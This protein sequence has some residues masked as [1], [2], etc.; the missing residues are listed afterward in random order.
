MRNLPL[1]LLVLPLASAQSTVPSY[2]RRASAT[3]QI[4]T[5]YGDFAVWID[6]TKWTQTDESATN[7]WGSIEFT[8]GPTLVQVWTEPKSRALTDPMIEEVL[9]QFRRMTNVAVVTLVSKQQRLVGGR[10]ILAVQFSITT[11]TPV[12]RDGRAYRDLRAYCYL[13]SGTSGSI[14]LIGSAPDT[15][16]NHEVGDIANFLN[17]VEIYDQELPSSD[18]TKNASSISSSAQQTESPLI[19][20]RFTWKALPNEFSEQHFE[21][22]AV[23]VLNNLDSTI[24]TTT[25]RIDFYTEGGVKLAERLS[26][27]DSV[28]AHARAIFT[29]DELNNGWGKYNGMA[30]TPAYAEI[31]SVTG[32]IN[33]RRCNIL[34][35][36]ELRVSSPWVTIAAEIAAKEAEVAARKSE[37]AAQKAAEKKRKRAEK[38][39]KKHKETT[40]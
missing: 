13:Y 7:E 26:F 39:K 30:A 31:G 4:K 27:M 15:I 34:T 33:G 10:H 17:G 28:P 11:T 35:N 16:F 5:A 3:K 22:M 23:T 2:T 9:N 20:E 19:I 21:P 1:L 38:E 6:D 25:I 8:K 18:A 14:Q 40:Q 36:G 29:Y 37:I 32:N 24:T 12:M